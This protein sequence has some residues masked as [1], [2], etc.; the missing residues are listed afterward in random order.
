MRGK[1]GLGELTG[2]GDASLPRPKSGFVSHYRALWDHLYTNAAENPNPFTSQN[3]SPETS[4]AFKAR[5]KRAGRAIA[6]GSARAMCHNE[7]FPAG[8]PHGA[9]WGHCASNA[10]SKRPPAGRFTARWKQP[11]SE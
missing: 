5:D 1:P 3:A 2:R 8:G 9:P 11:F 6:V 10:R 7:A 4:H